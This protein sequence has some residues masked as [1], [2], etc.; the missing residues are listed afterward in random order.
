MI[1]NYVKQYAEE[2]E[3]LP[4]AGGW[5]T[6]YRN[7]ETAEDRIIYCRDLHDLAMVMSDTYRRAHTP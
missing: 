5:L 6:R 1:P 3:Q 4:I 2:H 7:Y